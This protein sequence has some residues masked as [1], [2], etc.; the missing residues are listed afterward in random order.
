M[1]RQDEKW[2]AQHLHPM[3]KWL[4]ILMEEVGE[5]AKSIN[6]MDHAFK[7]GGISKVSANHEEEWVQVAAVALQRVKA[8]HRAKRQF[9]SGS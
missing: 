5:V 9:V 4:A 1:A 3:G 6:D 2:G 7:G 8:L